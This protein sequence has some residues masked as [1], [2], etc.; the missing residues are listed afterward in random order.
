M[1][2]L[3]SLKKNIVF[4]TLLLLSYSASAIDFVENSVLSTGAWYK[5]AVIPNGDDYN[6]S[7]QVYKIDYNLLL[8]MGIDPSNID[9]NHIKL[10]GGALGAAL[11]QGYTSETIDDLVEIPLY[12]EG[13]TDLQFNTSDYILFYASFASKWGIDYTDTSFVYNL[14]PYSDSSF[15]YLTIDDVSEHTLIEDIVNESTSSHVITH[16]DEHIHYEKEMVLPRNEGLA[17]GRNL[18]GIEIDRGKDE[19]ISLTG[20]SNVSTTSNATLAYSVAQYYNQEILD[21][22]ISINQTEVVS[23]QI[24][25]ANGYHYNVYN[26]TIGEEEFSP[27]LLLNGDNN[28]IAIENKSSLIFEMNLDWLELYYS[29]GLIAASEPMS[30]RSLASIGESTSYQFSGLTSS[31]LIWDITSVT[32]VKNQLF[33]LTSQLFTSTNTEKV[34]EYLVFDKTL[35]ERKPTFL[36]QIDNQNL[37]AKQP[38]E[39]VIITHEK[40]NEGAEELADY[41]SSQYGISTQV[42][43]VGEIFNEFSAGR[44]DPTAIRNFLR[45]LYDKDPALMKYVLLFGDGSF[46]YKHAVTRY[47]YASYIPTYQS[48]VWN[49][50]I[51]TYQSD[52]YYALLEDGEGEW[53]DSDGG[54][55]LELA[56]GRIPLR[57]IE[58]MQTIVKKLK[59]YDN[60][61]LGKGGWETKTV[62]VA[63]DGDNEIFLNVAEGVPS[64]AIDTSSVGF[65]TNKFYIDSYPQEASSTG[66]SV[67]AVGIQSDIDSSMVEGALLLTFFGHGSSTKLTVE[68]AMSA[69]IISQSWTDPYRLPIV[70]IGSCSFGKFDRPQNP[71]TGA[72]AV[73][74]SQGGGIA[75]L[76]PTR[77][78]FASSN[79]VMV[80]NF[81]SSFIQ[82]AANSRIVTLGDIYFEAKNNTYQNQTFPYENRNFS[83]LG[84]PSMRLRIPKKVVTIDSINGVL[85]NT[86]ENDTL[87]SFELITVEGQIEEE[88]VFS[89]DF[90]GD[91]D[92]VIYDIP[93]SKQTLGHLGGGTE[94][95]SI[96]NYHV[97]ESV[98]FKARVK[99]IEGKYAFNFIMPNLNGIKDNE[100]RKISLHAFNQDS[101]SSASGAYKNVYFRT[102][103][104]LVCNEEDCDTEGPEISILLGD[105]TFTSGAII[106]EKSAVYISL[107]DTSG[108]YL[109]ESIGRRINAKLFKANSNEV[110]A[111]YDLND[112]FSYDTLGVTNSV[113]SGTIDSFWINEQTSTL[114]AGIYRLELTAWD[115]KLNPAVKSVYFEIVDAFDANISPNPCNPSEGEVYFNFTHDFLEIDHSVSIQVLD[116]SGI[117]IAN[118]EKNFLASFGSNDVISW[119]GKTDAG[120]LISSGIYTYH[121]TISSS[122]NNEEKVEAVERFIIIN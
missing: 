49:N 94:D 32:E 44:Q 96:T 98:L 88:G 76:S 74:F 108:I 107:E 120:G 71:T 118:I 28:S 25:S 10:Y 80:E 112:K 119:D 64:W 106:S 21:F 34:N 18:L 95:N 68:G 14:N 36:H 27:S 2:K 116:Q 56:V 60:S 4:L 39:L 105:S 8:Q 75:M 65:T 38:T 103:S 47:D 24:P 50:N 115:N 51:Y 42:V 23:A 58:D 19:E 92:V 67:T 102:S 22:T 11:P 117:V 61:S 63:D 77:L 26:Y 17:T 101:T 83:L 52:D 84:D 5:L 72:D 79:E 73:L 110:I 33:D 7:G 111:T 48:R 1:I 113:F 86:N 100:F 20:I 81:Y 85:Y 70:I 59:D 69:D 45:M 62:L 13:A 90:N 37:H 122:E 66:S 6:I 53:L 16:F 99:V 91:L 93:S 114:Q 54:A 15:Y 89:S 9:P 35:I 31:H 87:N 57:T 55:D 82:K 30:F 12:I 97:R 3:D 104:Q 46:D 121:V 41:R 29:R 78:V 109:V 43:K 40:F